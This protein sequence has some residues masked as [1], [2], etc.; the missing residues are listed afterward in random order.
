MAMAQSGD[1]MKGDES[2]FDRGRN[3]SVRERPRPEF[4]ALGIRA[5]SFLVY[6][7]V[8]AAVAYE[9]NIFALENLEVEDTIYS[10]AP[11]VTATSQWSRH[12]LDAFA[13]ANIYRYA[14]F[15]GQNAETYSLGA[16]GRL[17][18][19]RGTALRGGISHDYLVE[20]RSSASSPQ[21]AADPV[22][23]EQSTFDF[24]GSH[25]FNRLRLSA[26]V[27]YRDT[28]FEDTVS[29][30]GVPIDES[31]RDN[32]TWDLTARADYALSPALSVY[33]FAGFNNWDYAAPTTP[34]DVS[35]DSDGYRA[36]LGADFDISRLVRGQFQLGYME[37]SFDDPRVGDIDGLSML[38]KVEYFPTELVTLTF[39]AERS[40]Q[41]TGVIGAG[42]T[43]RTSVG[44]KADYEFLRN[45]I[46]S[47]GVNRLVDDYQGFDREDTVWSGLI[48][49][50]YLVN[51]RVGVN[52]IYNH[53][54]QESDGLQ[55]GTDF[56]VN[57]IQ[58]GVVV[59]Y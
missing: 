43:V 24:G 44:A 29:F 54:S 56:A 33:G 30:L 6:P 28:Q 59:Q 7:K 45:L 22:K 32:K 50:Y 36:G 35:R 49:A 19:V 31:Y 1:S 10:F 27:E 46:L 38:G 23:Y 42:G 13:R 20:P 11:S 17:D 58:L 57:R 41:S 53:Y 2:L 8:E 3:V 16:S 48:G 34:G 47:A 15:N 51:R 26:D 52:L 12:Q 5:G 14:D 4:D 55:A 21:N 9:D 18:V 40:V 39:N 25:E 37:H